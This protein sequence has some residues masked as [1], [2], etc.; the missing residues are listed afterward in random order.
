MS[1]DELDEVAHDHRNDGA[2]L[3]AAETY[4]QV[5]FRCFSDAWVEE[6]TLVS[7]A[8]GL[9]MTVS[10][11]LCA[12]L[13]DVPGK[14]E[15]YARHGL[16]IARQGRE[17]EFTRDFY[18]LEYS[19]AARTAVTHE[20]EGDL[21]TVAGLAGAEDSYSRAAN[22]YQQLEEMMNPA[23]RI[24]WDG[25]PEFAGSVALFGRIGRATEYPNWQALRDEMYGPEFT[26][27][28]QV[29]RRHMPQLVDHVLS[30]GSWSDEGG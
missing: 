21:R 16:L 1:T 27:R 4:M 19:E 7:F 10:A 3:A 12:R 14:G 23:R 24:G 25:E 15:L 22:Q 6:P 5:A 20:W 30:R 29:K 11:V 26:S 28:T 17:F 13:A 8:Y 18:E 2:Y 9:E